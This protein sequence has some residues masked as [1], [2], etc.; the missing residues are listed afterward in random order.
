MDRLGSTYLLQKV[1]SA[2]IRDIDSE[3]GQ[4]SSIINNNG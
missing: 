3:E 2:L 1:P 4:L